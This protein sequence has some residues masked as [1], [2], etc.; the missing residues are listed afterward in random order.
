M[1]LLK[2]LNE[3]AAYKCRYL[4]FDDLAPGRYRI[5]EF[6]LK[7]DTKFSSGKRL[8]IKIGNGEYYLILPKRFTDNPEKMNLQELNKDPTDFIFNGKFGD[9]NI[10]FKFEAAS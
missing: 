8:C 5:D 4:P 1:S 10:D 9:Y 3:T 7:N 2:F 6:F